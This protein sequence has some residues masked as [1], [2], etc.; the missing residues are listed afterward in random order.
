MSEDIGLK[1]SVGVIGAGIQGV[2]ISLCLIKKGFKVTLVDRDDPGKISASYGN[3]GHFSP[4]SSVPINRPDILV[5]IPS[6]LL[7]S[8]GPLALKWNYVHKMIPWFLKFIKI[9]SKKNMLHT[10][11]YM[12][13][14]LDLA[15]P[16]YDELFQDIDTLS[17][18]HI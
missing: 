17:L 18:I 13:Q 14:I 8:T 15:L 1:S 11:K 9:C 10:A 6:M 2:C 12:H 5:D 16:A 3:A 7:S 4:Y